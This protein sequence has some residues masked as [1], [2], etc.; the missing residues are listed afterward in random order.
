VLALVGGVVVFFSSIR[1]QDLV[2]SVAL[3]D[4]QTDGG[5]SAMQKT[6]AR[7]ANRQDNVPPR[8]VGQGP[9][10]SGPQG[11]SRSAQ[12]G[13]GRFPG[14]GIV[15]TPI[16]PRTNIPRV[17]ARVRRVNPALGRPVEPLIAILKANQPRKGYTGFQRTDVFGGR[18]ESQANIAAQELL[19]IGTL[20][21][22]KA[23]LD[24]GDDHIRCEA[25]R[26]LGRIE[27]PGAVDVLKTCL[28]DPDPTIQKL[29]VDSLRTKGSSAS[30]PLADYLQASRQR[31]TSG[32]LPLRGVPQP[33]R[34]M[35]PD[36]M[37]NRQ[38]LEAR[39]AAAKALSQSHDPGAMDALVACLR[40][41][42]PQIRS[43]GAYGLAK[44][45]PQGVDYLAQC[46]KDPNSDIRSCAVEALGKSGDSRAIQPLLA[47]LAD[48]DSAMFDHVVRAL[49]GL[50]FEPSTTKE[51]VIFYLAQEKVDMLARIG[52]SA[53]EPLID[54][55]KHRA[56]TCSSCAAMTLIRI[57]D[58]RAIEPLVAYL[59]NSGSKEMAEVY[60]TC[61]QADLAGAAE[62]WGRRHGYTIVR[63]PGEPKATWG[64]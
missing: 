22:V 5:K 19:R 58:T 62:D 14:S 17:K 23:C 48:G 15:N 8:A 36:T 53:V 31:G 57:G 35:G 12:T 34:M 33:S 47:R 9:G 27:D 55:L 44:I 11:Q 40:D 10:W 43:S 2:D 51:K 1:P 49:N 24:Y 21:A 50:R 37:E 3:L 26:A 29:A 46:L 30:A 41:S 64:R 60:L 38:E 20:E 16:V 4:G 45:G 6:L 56:A 54:G 63:L 13:A 52:S 61:G 39:R 59:A 18:N 7:Y 42:D 25:V 28:E 32:E